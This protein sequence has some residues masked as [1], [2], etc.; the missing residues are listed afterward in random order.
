MIIRDNKEENTFIK[1]LIEAIRNIDT[2]NISNVD[3]LNSIIFEFASSMENIWVK[4]SKV[5]NITKHSK[6]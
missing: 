5:V 4:N 6:I 2:N 1:K 3:C